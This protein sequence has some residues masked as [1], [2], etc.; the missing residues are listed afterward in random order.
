LKNLRKSENVGQ[1]FKPIPFD[2]WETYYK[3]LLTENREPYL[4]KQENGV[5]KMR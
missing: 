2:K 4:R 3:G 5:E 1:P